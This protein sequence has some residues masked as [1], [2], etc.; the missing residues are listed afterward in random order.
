MGVKREKTE[1]VVSSLSTGLIKGI[2]GP[3][4]SGKT[5]LLYQIIDHLIRRGTPLMNI[6]MLNF[7]DNS[8]Y[9]AEF[10]TLLTEC[11]KINPD[12]TYIFLDKVQER[13]GWERWVRTLYDTGQFSQI[14]VTGSS[15]SLLKEDVA[16]VLTGR[17][18]TCC[19]FPSETSHT[20]ISRKILSPHRMQTSRSA[21]SNS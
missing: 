9:A 14:F 5:A 1:E 6:L 3:R 13:P 16:R 2:I 4:C 17:H 11:R 21:H 8:I 18:S 19:P 12:L 15:S 10:E 20:F 7:D